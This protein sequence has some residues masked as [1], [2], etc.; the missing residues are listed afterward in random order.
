MNA[1]Q[2]KENTVSLALSRRTCRKLA[3]LLT[4]LLVGAAWA[5][6]AHDNR[7]TGGAH[8]DGAHE[9]YAFHGRDVHRFDH[10]EQLRWSGGHWRNSCFGGR[11]GWWWFTGGLWYFYDQPVY[12]YPLVVS[13]I[14]YVDPAMAG[15]GP[16]VIT[17][18]P[19]PQPAPIAPAP[20]FW[21][22]CD[23]PQGYFPDVQT[24][25]TQFRQVEPPPH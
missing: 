3:P 5:Q 18:P 14:Q 21:Y 25:N 20:Q 9:R 19:V 4:A 24:C 16:A 2:R 6:P 7:G 11:C 23:N 13:G 15:P 12:P 1:T 10:G 22:Y 17:A 8:R